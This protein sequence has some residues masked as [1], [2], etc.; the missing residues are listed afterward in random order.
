MANIKSCTEGVSWRLR[1]S[2]PMPVCGV[3]Q[4]V[5]NAS[6]VRYVIQTFGAEQRAVKSYKATTELL[7]S[8]DFIGLN[9]EAEFETANYNA[10]QYITIDGEVLFAGQEKKIATYVDES[11]IPGVADFYL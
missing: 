9:P 5:Y 7:E 10:T 1:A 8:K 6:Q 3:C 4:L 11:E 2:Q